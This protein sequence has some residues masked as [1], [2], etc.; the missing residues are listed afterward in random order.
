[1]F[2]EEMSCAPII[3]PP[4]IITT[5][6]LITTNVTNELRRIAGRQLNMGIM[7]G[8]QVAFGTA[9][10]WRGAADLATGVVDGDRARAEAGLQEALGGL[11]HVAGAF[12]VPFS[13]WFN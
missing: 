2:E 1:L 10:M 8:R 11:S 9:D 12:I 13:G 6:P 3:N 7:M 5:A 4:P